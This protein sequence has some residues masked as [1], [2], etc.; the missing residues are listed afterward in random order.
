MASR[1]LSSV[2]RAAGLGFGVY[3]IGFILRGLG[4]RAYHFGFKGSGFRV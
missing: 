4:L 2:F 3:M 1:V